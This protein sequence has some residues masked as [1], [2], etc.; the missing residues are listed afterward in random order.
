[1]LLFGLWGLAIWS[2]FQTLVHLI[3]GGLLLAMAGSKDKRESDKVT[4]AGCGRWLIGMI[5]WPWFLF[6]AI[7]GIV[8]LS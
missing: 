5:T 4:P 3:G 2:A 6:I 1:M 8:T 7:Y